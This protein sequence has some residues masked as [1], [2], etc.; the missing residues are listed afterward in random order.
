MEIE[1]TKLIDS[2]TV[3]RMGVAGSDHLEQLG[4]FI[5]GGEH[6]I[7]FN[8][9]I[10]IYHP[11]VTDFQCSVR[12]E[13]FYK[14]LQKFETEKLNLSLKK[15]TI[16]ILGTKER[17]SMTVQ[18]EKDSEL[19]EIISG[20]REEQLNT[21]FVKVPEDFVH[22]VDFCSHSAS[23]NA[24]DGTLCCVCIDGEK[25][26]STDNYRAT[27]Y[28]M[29]SKLTDEEVLLDARVANEIKRFNMTHFGIGT[30]WLHFK[31]EEDVLL[32]ARRIFGDY[33]DISPAFDFLG[34]AMVLPKASTIDVLDFV[35]VLRA[36]EQ[37]PE[38]KATIT[39]KDGYLTASV[40]KAT[41]SAEK[42]TKL[43]EKYQDL[44]MAFVVN[45]EFLKAVLQKT[46]KMI[47]DLEEGKAMF[48]SRNFMHVLRLRPDEET[49]PPTR[50]VSIDENEPE[51][52][53]DP[54]DDD[55]PF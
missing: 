6:L 11:F 25:I 29:E 45:I 8:N 30:N 10:M 34:K 38:R 15:K 18:L 4:H 13:L 41:E 54:Y 43:D 51:T 26:M 35:G 16:T 32:S 44:D 52:K 55:I 20:I 5:F 46:P 39:I 24:A 42:G 53:T 7:T 19:F 27:R 28:D 22:A 37:E 48:K 31:N 14:Q 49:E 21:E 47:Y 12:A 9:R 1:K 3:A 36:K 17:A 2:L 23:K 50:D 33:M 40:T